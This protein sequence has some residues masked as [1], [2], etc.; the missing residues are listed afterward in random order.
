MKGNI[1]IKRLKT[2]EE[3]TAMQKIEEFVWKMPP[4]PIHQTYTAINHGGIILGAYSKEKLIGFLY[5]FPGYD[6]KSSYLCSHMLGVLSE[7]RKFGIGEKMKLKQ[8]ELAKSL[9]FSVIIWTYDPLESVNAYF[10]IHKLSATGAFY[11]ENHYGSMKDELNEGL[12]SDRIQIEWNL[13]EEISKRESLPVENARVLLI[14][15]KNDRPELTSEFTDDFNSESEPWLVA[16]PS[17]FQNL[18]RNNLNLA[19][20]WRITTRKVMKSLFKLEYKAKDVV[21]TKDQTFYVFTKDK[22]GGN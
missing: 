5:S 9:G 17:D 13:N 3:L 4:I 7:Y 11:K 22:R 12:P 6:G 2:I 8:A 15:D 16:I 20:E 21:R 18:K 10:N 19:K 14:K 1:I